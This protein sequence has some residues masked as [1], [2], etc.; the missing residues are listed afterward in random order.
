MVY[1]DK[2]ERL[3]EAS[4]RVMETAGISKDEA[5]TDICRAI[6]DGGIKIRCKLGRQLN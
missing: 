2:W 6:A 3:S 5:Q 1:V 4:T